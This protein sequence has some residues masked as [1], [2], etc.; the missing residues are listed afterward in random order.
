VSPMPAHSS[1]PMPIDDFTVPVRVP[2]ASVT[3]TCS[4]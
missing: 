1:E 2:P 3:P 4:G